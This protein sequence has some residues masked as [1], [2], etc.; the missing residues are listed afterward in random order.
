[1][2]QG[3]REGLVVGRNGQKKGR[4]PVGFSFVKTVG[5]SGKNEYFLFVLNCLGISL[6]N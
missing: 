4:E 5:K 2:D 3:W 6:K 1:M